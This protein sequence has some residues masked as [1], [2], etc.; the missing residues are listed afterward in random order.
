MVKHE[1]GEVPKDEAR[2]IDLNNIKMYQGK[3]CKACTDTGYE[4]RIGIYEVMPLS[5][6]LKSIIL[7]KGS[8]ASLQKQAISEGMINMK[9]DGY[10]KVLQG[11]T[12]LEEVIRV[13]KE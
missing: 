13:T 3:G 1:L 11:L 5:D 7:E 9:Q 10:I 8:I 12:T 4:G 6:S 2:D